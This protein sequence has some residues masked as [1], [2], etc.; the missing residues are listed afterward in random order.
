M[1]YLETGSLMISDIEVG[2]RLRAVNGAWVEAIAETIRTSGLQNPIEVV[3]LGNRLRLVTGAHRLA[4][5]QRLGHDSIPA[6]VMEAESDQPELEIREREIVENV[7]RHELTAIDRAAHL[8]ELKRIHLVL[9]P[10]AGHGGDRKSKKNRDEIKTPFWRLD[11]KAADGI[12]LS[13]RSVQRSIEI[14]DGLSVASRKRVSAS[15]LADHQA[16]LKQL[17]EVDKSLQDSVLDLMLCDPPK[18]KTVTDAVC[19]IEKR[20]K[21]KTEPE[22]IYKTLTKVWLSAPKKVKRD[23]LEFLRTQGVKVEG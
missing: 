12:R 19:I 14:F 16:Q 13:L 18:A 23:F 17:S 20:P 7:A 3:K 15:R 6:R 4:A 5:V 8:A 9:H 22:K 2:D 1:K 10:D 21:A 11:P